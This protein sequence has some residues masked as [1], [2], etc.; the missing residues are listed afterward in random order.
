MKTKDIQ[1][2]VQI[3]IVTLIAVTYFASR[4]VYE[5]ID[6]HILGTKYEHPNEHYRSYGG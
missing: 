6:E 4:G 3:I 1:N 2:G 5:F